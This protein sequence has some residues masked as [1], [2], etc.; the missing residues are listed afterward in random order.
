MTDLAA[1]SGQVKQINE[2]AD[3]MVKGGHAEGRKIK[4]RQSQL[5]EKYV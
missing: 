5:N 4:A 3:K 1:H 2:E